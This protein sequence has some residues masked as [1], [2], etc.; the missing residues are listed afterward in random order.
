MPML[1]TKLR[2]ATSDLNTKKKLSFRL[3]QNN[4]AS[5]IQQAIRISLHNLT[6]RIVEVNR[7]KLRSRPA[8]NFDSL[9]FRKALQL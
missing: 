6:V 2:Y 9:R 3:K 4:A 7:A 8:R 1:R 5:L